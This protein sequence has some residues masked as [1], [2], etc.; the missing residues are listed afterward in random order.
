MNPYELRGSASMN[1][2]HFTDTENITENGDV[3]DVQATAYNLA[4]FQDIVPTFVKN[5]I[6]QGPQYGRCRLEWTRR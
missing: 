3:G 2:S 5:N 1:V 4:Y 6:N